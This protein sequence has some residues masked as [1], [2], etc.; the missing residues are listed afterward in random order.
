V[1]KKKGDYLLFQVV[2]EID[3]LNHNGSKEEAVF[4]SYK[5]FY[6]TRHIEC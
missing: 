6:S 4:Q 2:L 3:A 1:W 5:A